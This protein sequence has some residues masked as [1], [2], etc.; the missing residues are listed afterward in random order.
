MKECLEQLY[1]ES[2]NL[3]NTIDAIV[4]EE[5]L[6]NSQKFLNWQDRLNKI[7]IK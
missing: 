7:S 2:I 6:E 3:C 5:S 4:R 1:E